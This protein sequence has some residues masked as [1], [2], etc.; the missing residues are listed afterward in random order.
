MPARATSFVEAEVEAQLLKGACVVFDP[1]PK[2]LEVHGLGA[3]ESLLRVNAQGKV[4]IP[5]VNYNQSVVH[6]DKGTKLG[7]IEVVCEEALTDAAESAHN[8]EDEAA[9]GEQKLEVG[10]GDEASVNGM[11]MI[12]ISIS[13]MSCMLTG[14][15]CRSLQGSLHSFCC[16]VAIP[17]C[18]RQTLSRVSAPPIWS[19]W[20]ITNSILQRDW[21][22]R[23]S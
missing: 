21:R 20:T 1:D 8:G 12:G 2:S 11:D 15:R 16:M 4:F 18:L 7:F 19:T 22:M 9:G 3:T 5:M 10:D 13:H 17:R 6:L 23:G 14:Y